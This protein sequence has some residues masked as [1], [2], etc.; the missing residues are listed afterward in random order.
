MFNVLYSVPENAFTDLVMINACNF[1]VKIEIKRS[2]S[3]FEA[4][5]FN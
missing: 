4:N 2:H 3:I 5:Y 1:F